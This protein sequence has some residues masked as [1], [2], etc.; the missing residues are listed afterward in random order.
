MIY[1]VDFSQ[2]KTFIGTLEADDFDSF[3]VRVWI[4][5]SVKPGNYFLRLVVSDNAN[6]LL[7]PC[8]IEVKV[9]AQ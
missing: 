7:K 3:K 4:P 9:L 5:N 2:K 6:E 1:S 8:E